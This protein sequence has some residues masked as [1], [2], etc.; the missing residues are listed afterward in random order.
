[1]FLNCERFLVAGTQLYKRLCPSVHPCVRPSVCHGDRV[2]N[3]RFRYIL[4]IF[5]CWRWVWVKTGLGC[6]CPPVRND[7]VTPRNLFVWHMSRWNCQTHYVCYL[8]LR[9]AN[10]INELMCVLVVQYN[11]NG[12]VNKWRGVIISLRTGGQGQP[13]PI[14][15]C[16]CFINLK[17]G[18]SF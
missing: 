8:Y 17:K 9:C 13:T 2:E 15:F 11:H 10:P 5:E 4:C 1:M 6:P 18:A 16:I 14:V 3:E 12:N 7:I